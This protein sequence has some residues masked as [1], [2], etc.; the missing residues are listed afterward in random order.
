[1]YRF[2]ITSTITVKDHSDTINPGDV[3]YG[4][5]DLFPTP[6]YAMGA[7]FQVLKGL[8]GGRAYRKALETCEISVED[9]DGDCYADID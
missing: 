6:E 5:Q 3:L 7:G 9:E 1:M 8:D 2:K 4:D